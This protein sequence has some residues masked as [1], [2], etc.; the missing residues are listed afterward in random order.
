MA[1]VVVSLGVILSLLFMLW[2]RAVYKS[3]EGLPRRD[4]DRQ[5]MVSLG[6][7]T[8]IMWTTNL[9]IMIF[10]PTFYANDP[11]RHYTIW[12]QLIGFLLVFGAGCGSFICVMFWI[13]GLRLTKSPYYFDPKGLT[14]DN[15]GWI[16][17]FGKIYRWNGAIPWEVCKAKF[18]TRFHLVY[19]VPGRLIR[20]LSVRNGKDHI[21][22]TLQISAGISATPIEFDKWADLVKL[23][24]RDSLDRV[25]KGELKP[26]QLSG[27]WQF[28]RLDPTRLQVVA[29]TEISKAEPVQMEKTPDEQVRDELDKALPML[30]G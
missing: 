21:N 5:F 30:A 27:I 3:T 7:F 18:S 13:Y 26:D 16:V 14:M 20:H 10:F 29:E 22:V 28:E 9:L 1:F 17:T 6:L 19:F 4:P 15:I 2:N 8:V 25:Q 24:V 23:K 11:S 12:Q